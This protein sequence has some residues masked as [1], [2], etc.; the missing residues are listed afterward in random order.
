M[1]KS[2]SKT[3]HI[4]L[5]D[6]IAELEYGEPLQTINSM[7][8]AI[9]VNVASN[10]VREYLHHNLVPHEKLE[11]AKRFSGQCAEFFFNTD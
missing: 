1:K 11:K 4:V 9:Y 7:A 5:S 10:L 2:K 3:E 8:S 6:H